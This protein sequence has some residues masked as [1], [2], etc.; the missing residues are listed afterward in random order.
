MLEWQVPLRGR[1]VLMVLAKLLHRWVLVP[2]NSWYLWW[3]ASPVLSR[4]IRQN[5]GTGATLAAEVLRCFLQL[6]IQGRI[7]A[8]ESRAVVLTSRPRIH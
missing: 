4:L 5:E 3:N 2:R 1:V 7:L 8:Q 6:S